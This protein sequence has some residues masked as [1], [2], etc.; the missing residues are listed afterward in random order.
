MPCL[1]CRSA[2]SPL[3]SRCA[4]GLSDGRRV[5]LASGMQIVCATV[6][7]GLARD[8]V[9]LLKYRAVM[10]AAHVLASAMA[11]VLP[12]GADALVPIPRARARRWRY[13]VD[14]ALELAI[15]LGRITH[16]PVARL[17]TPPWW[18]QRRAGPEGRLRGVPSFVALGSPPRG[19]VLVDDV[20]TTGT[21]LAA[22]SE[23]LGG[24]R[25]AITATAPPSR[26]IGLYAP[27]DPRSV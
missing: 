5:R 23:A 25:W 6:H 2:G 1:V 9:H 4:A 26:A 12:I 3:C 10:A 16:V 24:V 17:L 22:A 7:R 13:G 19:A 14:P 18:V 20:V 21:T 11:L 15:A 27:R 8:L